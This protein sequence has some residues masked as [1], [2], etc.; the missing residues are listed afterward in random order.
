MKKATTL[1]ELL[2]GYGGARKSGEEA[3]DEEAI[4]YIEDQKRESM[5]DEDETM[6]SIDT[7]MGLNSSP[8]LA[9]SEIA[10]QEKSGG[11]VQSFLMNSRLRK[12]DPQPVKGSVEKAEVISLDDDFNDEQNL[13]NEGAEE[14]LTTVSRVTAPSN[15]KKTALKD[16]F[17]SFKPSTE[18]QVK[19]NSSV[20]SSSFI[21]SESRKSKRVVAINQA[22]F[23]SRQLIEPP[24]D[25]IDRKG[26]KICLNARE[27]V[28]P[29]TI[30][31]TL[32]EYKTLKIRDGLNSRFRRVKIVKTRRKYSVLWPELLKPKSLKEVLLEPSLKENVSEWVAQAFIKLKKPTTRNKMLK[33]QRIE[34]DPLDSFIVDDE[35]DDA[36]LREDFVPLMIL[37]GD[38]IGKNVLIEVLMKDHGGQIYEVNA[39]SNRSKKDI[40]ESL[41]EFSTTH[42]VKGQ[43]SK[44]IILLDD[45]DVL[46]KE[47][48]KFFWQTIEKVLLTTRRPIIMLCRDLNFV[49]SNLV[50]LAVSE[51]SLFHCK[52][53]SH[54]TVTKFL[55]RYCRKLDVEIDQ[56]ILQVLVTCSK[57][58]IRKCLMDLEFCCTPPGELKVP[59][60][61][62]QPKPPK[63]NLAEALECAE[64]LSWTDVLESKTY[65]KSSILHDADKTLMTPHTQA[66]VGNMSDEQQRLQS[67]YMVDYR[68]HLVDNVNQAQLPFELN[69]G[70]YLK[71][72][73]PN[74]EL[75]KLTK[76]SKLQRARYDKMKKASIS[77][78]STRIEKK[79]LAGVRFRKTRNSRKI[80]EI[81]EGFDGSC[82]SQDHNESVVFDF[83]INTSTSIKE[84]INPY[85][86]EI[87]KKEFQIKQENRKLFLEQCEGV[88]KA[89]YNEVAWRL[90]RERLLKPIWFQADPKP[91]IDS[92]R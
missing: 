33:R 1:T 31:F 75:A 91:V 71:E 28:A 12:A 39:S 60:A 81:L 13:E 8:S 83:E 47:H 80:Q 14:L 69:I 41:L 46:F 90:T 88:E 24:D 36:R 73:L 50:H 15:F 62:P 59:E 51:N 19:L 25:I 77:Y 84:Q 63:Q 87:A 76:Y 79:G 11:S 4:A 54:Q 72:I 58:D 34:D 29:Q 18:K 61:S 67:D 30:P 43:G 32:D 20:V 38:G 16:L 86:L 10:S 35:M 40:L 65:W 17:N 2:N 78:L 7:S 22:P 70:E 37:F 92:W 56:S 21:G 85:V 57:K 48:D 5:R 68:L 9:T 45:V 42:Y 82:S 23:P 52:R 6:E 27:T 64:L 74:T 55:E 66:M 3:S 53:V 44:G 26:L 89:Q 49:P